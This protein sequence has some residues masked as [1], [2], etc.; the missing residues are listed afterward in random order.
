MKVISGP[1]GYP[2]R[3]DFCCDY[4]MTEFFEGVI[5]FHRIGTEKGYGTHWDIW[6]QHGDTKINYCPFCGAKVETGLV[7]PAGSKEM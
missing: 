1:I 7:P 6:I 4:I 5:T 2:Q 3:I